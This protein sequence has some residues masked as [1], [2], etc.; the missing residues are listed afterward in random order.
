MIDVAALKQRCSFQNNQ[1]QVIE[2]SSELRTETP[3]SV[4]MI[5]A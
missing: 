5:T 2:P 1:R 3:C 4:E